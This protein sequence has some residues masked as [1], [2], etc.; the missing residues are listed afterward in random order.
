MR[1]IHIKKKINDI[2]LYFEKY[3]SGS[4]IV[5]SYG[6]LDD[7]SIWGSQIDVFAKNNTMIIYD[8]RGHGSSDKSKGD[9]SIKELSDDM[10]SL[11]EELRLEKPI[12]VGFS[13]GGMVALRFALEHPDRLTKLV[14][15]GTTAK[16][17]LT[18]HIV[19]FLR[20]ILPY[21]TIARIVCKRKFYKP[22]EQITKEAL[23]RAMKVD[24]YVAYKYL[25]EFT[26]NYDIRYMIPL[27]KVPTLI[28]IGEKDKINLKAS[29]YL[30][31][32]IEKSELRI[33]SGCGHTVM[34][35]KP[36][37]FNH[38]VGNFIWD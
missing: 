23:S 11:I 21:K 3:G 18:M 29:K 1:R 37:E 15:V 26:K 13:L 8:H 6:W 31:R 14:L 16:M 30:N 20:H 33:V 34:V 17:A 10:Y 36:D 38:I 7:C 19:R 9:Y 28:I 32:K 27:I 25:N 12:I 2:E 24:R 35:E 4:P 22:S 5:F